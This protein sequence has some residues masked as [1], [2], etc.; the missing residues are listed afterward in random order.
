MKCI[1]VKSHISYAREANI[2]TD[3]DKARVYIIT[4][5]TPHLSLIEGRKRSAVATVA[6][7]DK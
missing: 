7:G 5:M 4:A 1:C 6:V 3:D 2:E